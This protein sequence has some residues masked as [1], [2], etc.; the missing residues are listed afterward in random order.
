MAGQPA[1]HRQQH[2]RKVGFVGQTGIEQSAQVSLYAVETHRGLCEAAAEAGLACNQALD[3]HRGYGCAH[4][5]AN[6]SN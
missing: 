4:I 6:N 1:H 5:A 3:R 2:A